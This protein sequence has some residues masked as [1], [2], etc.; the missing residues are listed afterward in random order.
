MEIR[1][2]D[3]TVIM[4]F[5]LKMGLDT[6]ELIIYAKLY[7]F[8]LGEKGFFIGGNDYLAAWAKCSV[9]QIIRILADFEAKK[10]V[11]RVKRPGKTDIIVIITPDTMSQVSDIRGDTMSRVPL[12]PCHDTPDTMSHDIIYNNILNIIDG[13]STEFVESI[14]SP[15]LNINKTKKTKKKDSLPSEDQVFKYIRSAGLNVNPEEF[16]VYYTETVVNAGQ[17]PWTDKNG[18]PIKN[19]KLK[20]QTWHKFNKKN[21][22]NEIQDENPA[23]EYKSDREQFLADMQRGGVPL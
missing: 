9:R 12:T 7:G 15:S 3:Y 14:P 8:S 22:E 18:K 6:T 4:P 5:M 1:E 19:W 21:H 11:K 23:I 13:E 2:S 10:F 16:W 17:K 20:A